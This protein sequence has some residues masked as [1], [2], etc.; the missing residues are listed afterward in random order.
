MQRVHVCV[1]SEPRGMRESEERREKV[2]GIEKESEFT[3][4]NQIRSELLE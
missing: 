4:L 2:E 1:S 3:K